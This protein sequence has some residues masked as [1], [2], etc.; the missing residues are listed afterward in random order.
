MRTCDADFGGPFGRAVQHTLFD[1]LHLLCVGALGDGEDLLDQ[2]ED[3]GLVALTDLHAVL[4]HHDDVLRAVFRTM[5][6]ALL[7][8]PCRRDADAPGLGVP[9]FASNPPPR[10]APTGPPLAIL[11]PLRLL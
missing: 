1:S 6:G 11:R 3:L 7:R 5:L 9:L 2:L 8:R 4:Q 10:S